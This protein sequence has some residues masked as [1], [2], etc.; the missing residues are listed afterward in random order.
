MEE[1]LTLIETDPVGATHEDPTRFLRLTS[2]LEEWM[3]RETA[4]ARDYPILKIPDA[5]IRREPSP[6]MVRRIRKA[7]REIGEAT[8]APVR[9]TRPSTSVRRKSKKH[10]AR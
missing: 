3:A 7:W 4:C 1:L 9:T 10:V 5:W 8:S 2:E 6:Q